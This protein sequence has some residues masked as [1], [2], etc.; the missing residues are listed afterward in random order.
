MREI[1]CPLE[2][3]FIILKGKWSPIILWRMRL[4]NQRITDLKKIIPQ[5]SSKML[6]SHLKE[7]MEYGLIDRVE[8]NVYPKHTEYF[9]TELGK[10][11]IPIL[12]QLQQFGNQYLQNSNL[13]TNKKNS[14]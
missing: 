2:I 4:G 5:C 12:I 6:I 8:Y 10:E 3:A 1:T 9:L 11:L 13:L 7:L 14:V